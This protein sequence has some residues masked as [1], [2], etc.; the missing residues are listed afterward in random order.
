MLTDI[1][2]YNRDLVAMDS[3][4]VSGNLVLSY[5]NDSLMAATTAPLPVNKYGT[6]AV[7]CTVSRISGTPYNHV[8][9][10]NAA[11]NVNNAIE[12]YAEGSGF[13]ADHILVVSYFCK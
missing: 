10:V 2:Y 6:G 13:I 11:I 3:S 8:A 7:I 4:F 5:A 1:N 12:I 9:R